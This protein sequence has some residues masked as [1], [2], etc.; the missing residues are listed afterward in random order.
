M[1]SKNLYKYF[2]G[3][4]ILLIPQKITGNITRNYVGKYLDFAL[5]V[6]FEP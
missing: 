1:I 2:F 4:S 6:I 5:L 3:I